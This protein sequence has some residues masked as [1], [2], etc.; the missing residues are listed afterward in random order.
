MK[1][2]KS[3]L[4]QIIKEELEKSMNERKGKP[5][6]R[7]YENAKGFS[8]SDAGAFG[9]KPV[10]IEEIVAKLREGGLTAG[11]KDITR[12]SGTGVVID[13]D[14]VRGGTPEDYENLMGKIAER[15]RDSYS[16][17]FTYSRGDKPVSKEFK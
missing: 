7:F 6:L 9:D 12:K 13:M 10:D 5:S 17:K 14:I 15:L 16:L 3:Q 2:T 4:K 11:G 1:I 8:F